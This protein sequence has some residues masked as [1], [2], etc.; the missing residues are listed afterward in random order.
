MNEEEDH[1]DSCDTEVPS[2]TYHIT[3]LLWT[4]KKRVT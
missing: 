1:L 4:L 3:L 2:K